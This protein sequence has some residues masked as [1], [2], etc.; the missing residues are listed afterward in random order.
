M[1]SSIDKRRRRRGCREFR[2]GQFQKADDDSSTEEDAASRMPISVGLPEVNTTAGSRRTS[3]RMRFRSTTDGVSGSSRAKINAL[4]LMERD[5][6]ARNA[7]TSRTTKAT[8]PLMD[9]DETEIYR[10]ARAD[11]EMQVEEEIAVS[12]SRAGGHDSQGCH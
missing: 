6:I 4:Q 2:K 1:A 3:K 8:R 10:R 9:A 11:G 12:C 7:N 5:P